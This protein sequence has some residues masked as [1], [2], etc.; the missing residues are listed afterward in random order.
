MGYHATQ[1]LYDNPPEIPRAVSR[2]VGADRIRWVLGVLCHYADDDTGETCPAQST[3]AATLGPFVTRREISA[4]LD[5]LQKLGVITFVAAAIPRQ[6]GTTFRLDLPL[7]SGGDPPRR[8]ARQLRGGSPTETEQLRGGSPTESE[9]L[10]G[11]RVGDPPRDQLLPTSE[12]ENGLGSRARGA[13]DLEDSP[14]DGKLS[15][16]MV[17]AV[18]QTAG[19][20]RRLTTRQGITP[21][22]TEPV[23]IT[24]TLA[25]IA[26][27]G[28]MG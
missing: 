28:G 5:V 13:A 19:A 3:I 18:L 24:E 27:R 6:R 23:P 17:S 25:D 16:A 7:D 14:D 8:S 22:P 26:R 11:E 21:E 20:P 10:R 15:R 1:W 12:L 4:A 2:H 9:Q